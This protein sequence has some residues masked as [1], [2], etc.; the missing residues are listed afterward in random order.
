MTQH[1]LQ[2]FSPS[3]VIVAIEQNFLGF[4]LAYVRTAHGHIQEEPELTWVYTGTPLSYFNGVMRTSSPVT[5]G[6]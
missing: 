2:D 1:I 4:T 5:A 3:A 6:W